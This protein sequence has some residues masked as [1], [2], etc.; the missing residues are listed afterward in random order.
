[1]RRAHHGFGWVGEWANTGSSADRKSMGYVELTLLQTLHHANQQKVEGYILELIVGLHHLVSRARNNSNNKNNNGQRSPTKSPTRPGGKKK[2]QK[3]V[4]PERN[5]SPPP[6]N[7]FPS[8]NLSNGQ[9]L[10]QHVPDETQ[11]TIN[12]ELS[13][14][15]KDMLRD[16]DS[17]LLARKVIPGLSKSQ[18]FDTTRVAANRDHLRL[19]KSSSHSPSSTDNFIEVDPPPVYKPRNHDPMSLDI[20]RLNEHDID[21]SDILR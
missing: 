7:M 14:E 13:Q 1:V 10:P 12:P 21:G 6:F 15:D 17:G 8:E 3:F 18:E 2:P 4:P 16:I 19:S 20:D 11:S 9:F 5:I